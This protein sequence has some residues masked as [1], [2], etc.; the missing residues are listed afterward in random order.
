MTRSHRFAAA[1][2]LALFALPVQA[3]D[4]STVMATVNG[5]DITLGHLVAMRDRLPAEY[6]QL[7]DEALLRGLLDQA[8][9]QQALADTARGDLAPGD[10]Y[11]LEN[12]ERAFLAARVIE[13]A[14]EAELD[15]AA[16]QEAYDARFD[17]QV[18][19]NA[20]H[21]LVETE[22]EARALKAQLDDG[23]DFATLAREESTGPSGPSGGALG[24]FTTGMMVPAFEEAVQGLEPGEVS[25]PIQTQFGWH[26]V[27]LN[28]TRPVDAPPLDQ[29]RPD[30]EQTLRRD[31]VR[32]EIDRLTAEAEVERTDVD[33]DPALIR[34][35]TLDGQ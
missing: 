32:E 31:V 27:R 7:P 28:E 4:L 1:A 20:A 17:G 5:T 2:A 12:E 24:W 8:I 23:A 16:V 29:V 11:G 34:T 33:V 21:I 3:Q 30:I 15:E 22:T 13:R 6:Q 19:W 14:A 10:E 9:Q 26:V 25:D 18:E 35:M